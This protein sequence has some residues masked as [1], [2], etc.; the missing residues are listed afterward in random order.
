MRFLTMTYL[1]AAMTIIPPL[2][3]SAQSPQGKS[4]FEMNE[5]FGRKAKPMAVHLYRPPTWTPADRVLIVMHGRGRNGAEYRDQWTKQ[6]EAGNLLIVVPEFDAENFPGTAAYN[7][8]SVVDEQEKP[9]PADAWVFNVID[10]VHR[11]VRKQTGATREKYSLYGHSAGA[12]YVHR[13]LLLA[14]AADADLIISANA[15][16]YTMP[17]RGIAFPFGLD[18]VTVTDDDLKRAFARPVVVLLGDQDID[19]NHQSLPRQ[20]G[21]MAQGP[22]RFARGNLFFDTAQKKAAELGA[23]FN[24]RLVP[25]PGVAHSNTNMANKA[26]EIVSGLGR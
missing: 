23:P 4:T 7:W 14:K 10:A 18:G 24:W 8:G 3:A 6:S 22:H 2:T 11:E 5:R 20:P 13:F 9:L 19:P 12:Q 1:A 21:A 26:A 16:S 25:V 15:G 17:V